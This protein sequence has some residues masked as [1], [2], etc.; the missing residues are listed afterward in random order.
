MC[1]LA[2]SHFRDCLCAWSVR[3]ETMA[4]KWTAGLKL[5]G[6]PYFTALSCVRSSNDP[7]NVAL[8]IAVK[9]SPIYATRES[10]MNM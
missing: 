10:T 4:M 6:A 5:Q 3:T 1:A 7:L 2:G 9:H 8:P